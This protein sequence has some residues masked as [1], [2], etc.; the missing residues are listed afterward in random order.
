MKTIRIEFKVDDDFTLQT[1]E[2]EF[3]ST[4]VVH[5]GNT[6]VY[7]FTNEMKSYEP[8]ITVVEEKE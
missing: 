1:V 2:R 8:H 6:C 3:I 4:P 7:I 5:V